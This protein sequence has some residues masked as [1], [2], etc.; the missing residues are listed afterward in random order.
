M[1]RPNPS[2]KYAAQ[3]RRKAH[4]PTGRV[5]VLLS[6][7]LGEAVKQQRHPVAEALFEGLRPT[8]DA[9]L[10][11]TVGPR[12]KRGRAIREFV[13]MVQ[14]RRQQPGVTA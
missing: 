3:I 12:T 11:H 14:A 6:R 8:L 7:V 2:R 1:P 13:E 5:D 10:Q 9:Y 4:D